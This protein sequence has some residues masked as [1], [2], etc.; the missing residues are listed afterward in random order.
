MEEPTKTPEELA[1]E[2]QE[3]APAAE[4]T[5]SPGPWDKDLQEA[6]TDEG[7]RTQVDG[8]L[9]DK[10]QPHVTRLEQS[11]G[12]QEAER[13]YQ[14]FAD[15]PTDTYLAVSAELFGEEFA[16]GLVKAL[17]EEE[18]PSTTPTTP[19]TPPVKPPEEPTAEEEQEFD[20]EKL[21]PEIQEMIA[22]RRDTQAEQEY[23]A[24]LA[25]VKAD[26]STDV[27]IKDDW[28]HPFVVTA[29][30][31][32]ELAYQGYKKWVAEAGIDVTKLAPPAAAV[33]PNTQPPPTI[34]SDSAAPAVPP[35]AKDYH[36]NLDEALDDFFEQDV[37][38][39]P[40]PVVGGGV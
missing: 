19:V 2:Q 39:S 7:I 6:F 8:F 12:N 31:D 14:D 28:F 27:P 10:V 1:A 33:D 38:N 23:N 20:I 5:P 30:G 18:E 21:P 35:V 22:E 34:G 13:L 17:L 40:P 15:N 32:M 24:E 37:K 4:A 29:E 16:E 36:G 3:A 25:R 9:R 26:H 11:K